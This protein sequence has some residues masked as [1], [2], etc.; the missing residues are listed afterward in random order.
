TRTTDTGDEEQHIRTVS[1]L[2]NT[3]YSSGAGNEI[4]LDN[5]T[6]DENYSVS[7]TPCNGEMAG[8][9]VT[10]TVSGDAVTPDTLSGITI[11]GGLINFH[12]PEFDPIALSADVGDNTTHIRI[13][14]C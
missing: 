10:A 4:A 13:N 2:Q 6:A 11:G 12:D 5:V 7:V 14:Y 1:V 3:V 9:P 8:T